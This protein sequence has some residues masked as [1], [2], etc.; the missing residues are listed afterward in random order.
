MIAWA[1]QQVLDRE[2]A[3]VK[4]G[5]TVMLLVRRGAGTQFIAV[6]ADAATG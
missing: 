6:T 1:G 2:L 5:Q 3:G 4:P